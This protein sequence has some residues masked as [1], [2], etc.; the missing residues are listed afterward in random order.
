MPNWKEIAPKRAA[1]ARH[2][3]E[4]LVNTADPKRG[5]DVPPDDARAMLQGLVE[6][7]ARVLE[8]YKR[9]ADVD[10]TLA[11]DLRPTDG[12]PP[13]PTQDGAATLLPSDTVIDRR[14][15]AR[16]CQTIPRADLPAWAALLT[17]R[18]C[19]EAEGLR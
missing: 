8:A 13:P 15:I 7:L 4:L 9:Q 6:A 12:S 3:L 2:A 10:V 16:L 18:I 17:S 11:P 19:E 1:N 5:Y 14:A